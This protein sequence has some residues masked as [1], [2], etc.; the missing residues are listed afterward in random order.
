MLISEVF[1][2]S[3]AWQAVFYVGGEGQIQNIKEKKA[4]RKLAKEK[5][6]AAPKELLRRGLLMG[7]EKLKGQLRDAAEGGR[8]EDTETD[9]AQNTAQAMGRLGKLGRGKRRGGGKPE[10]A[11]SGTDAPEAHA[12]MPA[13]G[14]QAGADIPASGAEPVRIRPGKLFPPP[15]QRSAARRHR[16][17]SGPSR[18]E[19]TAL[20]DRWAAL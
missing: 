7:T 3:A 2:P 15:S 8:R 20:D 1:E 13:P 18:R 10:K 4:V 5:I 11:R 16:L 14:S 19:R 9:R 6:R 12:D 17:Y